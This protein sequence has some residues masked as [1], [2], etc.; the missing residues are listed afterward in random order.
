MT[1]KEG[2]NVFMRRIHWP[3]SKNLLIGD[4]Q[5][6]TYFNP[7]KKRYTCLTVFCLSRCALNSNFLKEISLLCSYKDLPVPAMLSNFMALAL[8]IFCGLVFYIVHR[9][10]YRRVEPRNEEQVGFRS[11][12]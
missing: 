12:N 3:R 9:Y 2:V 1:A 5:K 7:P 4:T 11:F 10:D 8:A 6:N